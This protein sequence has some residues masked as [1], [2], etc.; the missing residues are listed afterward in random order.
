MY[1]HGVFTCVY[2]HSRTIHTEG[3]AHDSA[4]ATAPDLRDGIRA[5]LHLCR[6]AA[7]WPDAR[8]VGHDEA[9]ASLRG[10]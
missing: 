4:R 10:R 7:I 5:L 1:T 2:Y 6:R 9:D 3:S 8:W